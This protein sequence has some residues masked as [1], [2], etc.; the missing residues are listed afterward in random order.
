M[1]QRFLS[2]YL[3]AF[4]AIPGWCSP[5]AYLMFMAYHQLLA[6]E[7]LAGDV[8][9]IGVHHGLSAIGV[10]ALRGEGRRFVAV[11]LFEG[12]QSQNVSASGLGDLRQFLANMH[13][14]H[15]DVSFMTVH[16]AHSATLRPADLGC[17]F[18]FCHIDGGHSAAEAYADLHLCSSITIPGGLIALDDYF[19]PAF[20]G[21]GEAAVRYGLEHPEMLRPI[22]IG[23]N[24]ALFQR[25]PAPFDLSERFA[26]VFPGVYASRVVMW[27]VPVR[28]FDTTFNAFFDIA[29]STPRRLAAVS[30]HPVGARIEPTQAVVTGAP[31]GTVSIEVQ[32]TN[33]SRI[34]LAH[35]SS[36]FGLSY[37]LL[38]EDRRLLRFD[39]AREWF[40]D[41][42][43]P[44]A[45]RA[46]HVR[47][48]VPDQPGTY[49]L[50]F[51]IVWEGVS[52]MKDLGNPTAIVQLT[53]SGESAVPESR[54]LE[55]LRTP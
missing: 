2:R 53:A 18:S 41:P 50:E 17:G 15:D 48:D 11:D 24:K 10:A 27:D 31:G 47:V 51:D 43:V 44:G 20:P 29:R 5:D 12:M 7:G 52:W 55:A 23:F 14:F 54:E 30:E 42:L 33:L 13:R 25:Q 40:T 28:K 38:T 9:E 22:A 45:S 4:G 3:E 16:T 8:L 6:D 21:V 46:L 1:D 34:P 35:G 19:N 36:P 49:A 37:H 39:H 26:S 32:V